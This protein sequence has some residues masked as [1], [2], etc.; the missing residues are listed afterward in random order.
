[1]SGFSTNMS[2]YE[3][4]PEKT[5]SVEDFVDLGSADDMTYANFSI[6]AQI[7]GSDNKVMYPE[8]NVI[9]DYMKEMKERC[10]MLEFKDEELIKYRY[11]P[12]RLAYDIYG[13]T[14]LYFIILAINGMCSF[15]DFNKKKI[16]ILIRD[17]LINLL[18]S[19]Y[20]AESGYISR[21]RSKLEDEELST[22]AT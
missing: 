22:N 16:K 7:L 13:S 21:N 18:T 8:N 5:M 15:K 3:S 4:I 9:Y 2:V 1:M 10:L 14:E 11:N 6:M 20:N 17:D 12:K 19:I